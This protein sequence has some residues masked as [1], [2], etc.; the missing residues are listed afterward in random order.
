MTSDEFQAWQDHPITEVVRRYLTDY[1]ASIR[2]DWAQGANWSEE[3][4]AKVIDLEDLAAL[5]LESIET[6]YEARDA[7]E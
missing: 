3:A 2:E 4:K 6:F 7:D 1:A 5:D